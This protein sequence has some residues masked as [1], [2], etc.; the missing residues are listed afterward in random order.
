M[1]NEFINNNMTIEEMLT[2]QKYAKRNNYELAEHDMTIALFDLNE[3]EE[4]RYEN[5]VVMDV[6]MVLY[7]IND[8]IQKELMR[9]D[10]TQEEINTL[11][12]DK[13][14]MN[15]LSLKRYIPEA[16]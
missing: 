10:L 3:A 1:Y 16:I 9:S 11:N 14:L 4:T 13:E 15:K 12:Y 7:K 6:E 8:L 5:P 2:I